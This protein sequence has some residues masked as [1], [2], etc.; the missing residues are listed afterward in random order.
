MPGADIA[1]NKV[2]AFTEWA[3]L[4]NKLY[5]S[6]CDFDYRMDVFW[7]NL[8]FVT[9]HNQSGSS[10]TMAMNGFADLTDEEFEKRF[11]SSNAPGDFFGDDGSEKLSTESARPRRRA[12]NVP[13]KVD[14][15]EAGKVT[16]VKDQ[17]RCASCYAF[18]GIATVES[19]FAI[20]FGTLTTLSEQSIVDCGPTYD[21]GL[22]GCTASKY[23]P[24]LD[25]HM[26][27]GV[28]KLS[29]W[30]YAGVQ[31][32]CRGTSNPLI[33]VSGYDRGIVN[34]DEFI[35]SISLGPTSVWMELNASVR[36]YDS[37]VLDV[38]A[39]CGFVMNHLVLAYGYDL[40]AQIP[41][42]SIKNSWGTEWGNKGYM[43]VRLIGGKS[44]GI[45]GWIGSDSARAFF[46]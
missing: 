40:D 44:R 7:A 13:R 41:Y 11:A 38:K 1:A 4:N 31:Q 26:D 28:W 9:R 14:W 20:R 19:A 5:A 23:K 18:A 42:Y 10:F 15:R 27:V 16:S 43:N 30:P 6:A 34:E 33:K 45:C 32:E 24:S 39:P 36:W 22:K 46:D 35:E 8:Q 12:E 29:D 37:G 25:F 2:A 21:K 3:F 17:L